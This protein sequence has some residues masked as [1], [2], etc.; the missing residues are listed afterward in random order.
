MSSPPKPNRF[1]RAFLFVGAVG[2]SA[3]AAHL[4]MNL[5]ASAPAAGARQDASSTRFIAAPSPPRTERVHLSSPSPSPPPPSSSP[6]PSPHEQDPPQAPPPPPEH[7]G[8]PAE[9]RQAAF[10]SASALVEA[11]KKS[12]HWGEQQAAEMGQL[13]SR[14]DP[15]QADQVLRTLIP[16]INAQEIRV[17]LNGPLF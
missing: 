13:F 17:D 2:I 11:A 12:K 5:T 15:Q 6:S 10:D 7:E 9:D 3:A 14:L 8:R 4:A 16:A 1:V